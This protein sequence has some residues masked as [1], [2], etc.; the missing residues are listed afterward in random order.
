[1]IFYQFLTSSNAL[2][3]DTMVLGQNV[4]ESPVTGLSSSVSTAT[5][6][7]I[8]ASA[9]ATVPK[10]ID[11]PDDVLNTISSCDEL[12]K[13]ITVGNKSISIFNYCGSTG[14]PMGIYEK[15]ETFGDIQPMIFLP[16]F[17]LR[18][19]TDSTSKGVVATIFTGAG[20]GLTFQDVSTKVIWPITTDSNGNKKAGSG[21][22]SSYINFSFGPAVILKG[23]L[24][25]T[26]NSVPVEVGLSLG[27]ADNHFMVVPGYDTSTNQLF[28]LLSTSIFSPTSSTH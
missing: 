14:I 8:A 25:S 20:G 19:A 1:M 27:F 5:A 21:V 22:K 7:E 17:D 13:T 2:T 16:C 12:V 6:P 18:G 26:T 11:I 4:G 9:P 3:L 15:S 10:S 24:S 23:T 28:F